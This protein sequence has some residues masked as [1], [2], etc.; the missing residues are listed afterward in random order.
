[1]NAPQSNLRQRR[2]FTLIE[3]LVVITIIALL[4]TIGVVGGN[5]VLINARKLEAKTAMKILEAAIK[6]YH[7]EYLRMPASQTPAPAE[8]NQAIDTTDEAGRALLNVLLGKDPERN[9]KRQRFFEPSPAKAG[10]AGYSTESGLRDPWGNGYRIIMDY[11][12]DGVIANPYSGEGEAAELNTNVI[13]YSAG[14][15]KTFD[16]GGAAGGKKV[17]DVRSWQP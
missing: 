14:P 6:S 8:D 15:N 5:I 16:E 9:P 17:D 11:S 1:M 13:I 12:A 3:L 10:G 4:A 7:A 2:G